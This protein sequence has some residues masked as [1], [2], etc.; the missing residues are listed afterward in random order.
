M[1]ISQDIMKRF[2][3]GLSVALL[4]AGCAAPVKTEHDSAVA[5][6]AYRSFAWQAPDETSVDDPELDSQMVDRRMADVLSASLTDAGYNPVETSAADFR[7]SYHLVEME[8]Q[9][10]GSGF[11]VGIGGSSGNVG[12]GISFGSGRGG[13]EL[14]LV[15]DVIDGDSGD[16]VWRGWSETTR[17]A[18]AE[19]DTLRKVVDRILAEFPPEA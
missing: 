4:M 5:F 18:L 11:S 17:A 8:S 9:G 3:A 12:S 6:E 2:L 10:S 1:R 7:V 15:I 19:V 14:H 13:P 16:L